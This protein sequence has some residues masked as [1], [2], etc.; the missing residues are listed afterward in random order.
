MQKVKKVISD[1]LP[2]KVSS[3]DNFIKSYKANVGKEQ[4]V[5][6]IQKGINIFRF[7]EDISVD[8]KLKVDGD[9][10]AK[11]GEKYPTFPFEAQA[12]E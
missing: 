2:I 7:K 4:T 8:E 10:G 11:T 6:D 9:Y 5:K 1:K 3:I 12:K